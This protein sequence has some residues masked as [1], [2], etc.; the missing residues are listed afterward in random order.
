MNDQATDY[1]VYKPASIDRV[2]DLIK[3]VIDTNPLDQAGYPLDEGLRKA[4]AILQEEWE[5]EG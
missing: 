4:I 5:K 3:L 2:I 1:L